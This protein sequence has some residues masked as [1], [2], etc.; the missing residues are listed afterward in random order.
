MR[1]L[2]R[3]RNVNSLFFLMLL[4]ILTLCVAGTV[5]AE[6]EGNE[7]SSDKEKDRMVVAKINGQPVFEDELDPYVEKE[8]RKYRKYGVRKEDPRL[9]KHLQKKVLDKMIS[10]ELLIQESQKLKI[11]DLEEK[12]DEK[13]KAMMDKPSHMKR[14]NGSPEITDPA[15]PKIKEN[16]RKNI[17]LDEYL[18]EQGISEPEIPEEDLRRFYEQGK[19]DFRK[20]EYIRV[21]HILIM[22]DEKSSEEEKDAARQKAGKIRGEI[23]NGKDFAA[24]AREFSQDGRAANGGNLDYITRGYMPPEFDAVAFSLKEDEVSEVVQ[25]KFGFHIIKLFDRK[26][27]GISSY[28]EVRDFIRKYLQM[29]LSKKKLASHIEELRKKASIEILISESGNEK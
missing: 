28:E 21:S 5:Y 14:A 6:P 7:A 12:V 3:K 17:Y 23:L 10:Q 25:T 11:E 8:I 27:A 22:A 20:D 1:T 15:D 13:I 4:M 19:E 9:E 26:P 18:K 29:E 24:M 2:K 16:I